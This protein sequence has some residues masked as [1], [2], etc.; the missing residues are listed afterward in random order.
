MQGKY[1]YRLLAIDTSLLS[2]ERT[3]LYALGQCAG[4]ISGEVDRAKVLCSHLGSIYAKGCKVG[5]C[6]YTIVYLC[7]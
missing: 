3:T 6:V 7:K 4:Y 5:I 2:R 1:E